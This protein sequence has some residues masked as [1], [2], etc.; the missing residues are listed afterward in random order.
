MP[1]NQRRG[2]GVSFTVNSRAG[3]QTIEFAYLGGAITA[4]REL[5]IEIT[6]RLQRTC[7]CFQLYMMNMYDRPGVRL[8]V[9]VRMLKAGVIET[10]LYGCMMWSPN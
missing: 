9:K 7:A 5:I 4:D 10:L 6:R 2:E 1:A 8:R 3:I